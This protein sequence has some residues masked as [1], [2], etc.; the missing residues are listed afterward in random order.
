[1]AAQVHTVLYAHA[2][3]GH[4]LEAAKRYRELVAAAHFAASKLPLATECEVCRRPQWIVANGGPGVVL[5]HHSYAPEHHTDVIPL[6]Q[7]CH[8]RVHAGTLPEPRT[9]RRYIR[10]GQRAKLGVPLLVYGGP[11]EVGGPFPEPAPIPEPVPAPEPVRRIGAPRP[12]NV[13][14]G[15]L[16]A[17]SMPA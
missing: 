15:R 6:C 1:M 14:L 10:R 17:A 11:V 2:P 9:G 13:E 16:R 5:H 4:S 7:S 3:A 8:R 12:S